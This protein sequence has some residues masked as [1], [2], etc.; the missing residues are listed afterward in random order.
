MS[1]LALNNNKQQWYGFGHLQALSH[2]CTQKGKISTHRD[3]LFLYCIFYLYLYL[4]VLAKNDEIISSLFAKT[5][6]QDFAK[7]INIYCSNNM[8]YYINCFGKKWWNYDTVYAGIF[9][10]KCTFNTHMHTHTHT[11]THS[12]TLTHTHTHTLTHT[13]THTHTLTHHHHQYLY[14]LHFKA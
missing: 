5:Q 3:W 14:Y 11:L 8:H 10:Q 12:L 1:A 2:E 9:T 4:I 6:G 13:H 7:T